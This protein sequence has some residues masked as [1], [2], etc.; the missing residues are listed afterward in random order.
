M[1]CFAVMVCVT[2]GVRRVLVTGEGEAYMVVALRIPVSA[3]IENTESVVVL[4]TT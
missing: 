4:E 2:C 1:R 3:P